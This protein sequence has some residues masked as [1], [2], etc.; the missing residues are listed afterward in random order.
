MEVFSLSFYV[1]FYSNHYKKSHA[2]HE[3]FKF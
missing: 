3:N 2:M 1:T